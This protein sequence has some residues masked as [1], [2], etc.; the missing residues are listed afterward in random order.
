MAEWPSPSQGPPPHER[1][2]CNA[3]APSTFHPASGRC[4]PRCAL[5]PRAPQVLPRVV[6]R[7]RHRGVGDDD[8]R[9]HRAADRPGLCAGCFSPGPPDW[10][11]VHRHAAGLVDLGQAGRAHRA[12]RSGDLE[13]GQL[14][15]DLAGQRLR[16]RLH[17]PVR[18]AAA[19]RR[20]GCGHDGGHLRPL[21]GVVACAP[22]GRLD[23]VPGVGLAHRHAPG[24]GSYG[25]ADALWLAHGHCGE[26]PRRPVGAGGGALGA[27]VAVLAGQCRAPAASPR[28]ARP[29]EPRCRAGAAGLPAAGGPRQPW[30]ATGAVRPRRC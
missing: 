7:L 19:V 1:S 25:V 30:P 23:G 29:P 11:H 15:R 27:G 8:H 24:A 16:A 4:F 18:V 17:H 28:S 2:Y 26:F 13:P 21:P 12:Q 6:L 20:G 3:R 9:L 10:C 14:R 22:A 5:D